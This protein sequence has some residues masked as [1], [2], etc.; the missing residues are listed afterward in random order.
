[1]RLKSLTLT[2]PL[3]LALMTI[4]TGLITK[5]MLDKALAFCYGP[6]GVAAWAQLQS[7]IDL[8]VGIIVTGIGQGL[9]V[10]VA[11]N[12]NQHTQL[13]N[14]ATHHVM[15]RG[16]VFVLFS[17]LTIL[18]FQSRLLPNW[19]LWC[20][21]P[22]I[23]LSF[24]MILIGLRSAYFLGLSNR[25][26]V[27]HIALGYGA[28]ALVLV[29]LMIL[30]SLTLTQLVISQLILTVALFFYLQKKQ[31]AFL[32]ARHT[33]GHPLE[34][35]LLSYLP[36]GI[37]IGVLSPLSMI[38]I[39]AML[40]QHLS[41]SDAG[42]VQA[43][44][45]TTDWITAISAGILSLVFLPKMSLAWQQQRL[46]E[47]I[48]QAVKKVFIPATCALIGFWFLMPWLLKLLYTQDFTIPT[49]AVTF[50]LLG[51][52]LRIFSWV[53]LFALFAMG[54]TRLIII[55]EFLSLPLLTALLWYQRDH[56]SFNTV[57]MTHAITYAI[58][59]LFN[60][61]AVWYT[62]KQRNQIT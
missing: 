52:F 26:E 35:S 42:I 19:P 32:P 45:R 27:L 25:I 40:G 11:Q 3:P 57:G 34:K 51:D 24:L 61:A 53:F 33:L 37:A 43:L 50:F 41:W 48:L 55:G 9:T 38:V 29:L 10:L 15:R 58:Y 5:A 2:Q 18:I 20:S 22:M 8:M 60:I 1:M 16:A 47:E 14:M 23:S 21:V 46:Y 31:P 6:Q 12:T 49:S 59:A 7:S 39:R 44:W 36:T 13:L 4:L 17:F 62:Q 56:L 30:F 28:T 54:K